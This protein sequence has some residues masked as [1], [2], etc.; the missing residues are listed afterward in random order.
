MVRRLTRD[1]IATAPF[2]PV[3]DHRP[4]PVAHVLTILGFTG[5]GPTYAFECRAPARDP[6]GD[7][8]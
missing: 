3:F 4:R 2:P 8:L 6:I 7:R 1:E 5:D